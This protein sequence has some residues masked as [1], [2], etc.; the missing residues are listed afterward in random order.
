MGDYAN[1]V[2]PHSRRKIMPAADT[3]VCAVHDGGVTYSS[4]NGSTSNSG[5][6][7]GPVPTQ[8]TQ[9]VSRFCPWRSPGSS[10]CTPMNGDL[11]TLLGVTKGY[12][13]Q[14]QQ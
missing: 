10:I 9:A 11:M 2:P 7:G 12:K 14:Q 6:T 8:H 4:T 1:D 3:N 5:T 13:V